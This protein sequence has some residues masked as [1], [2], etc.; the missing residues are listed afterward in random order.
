MKNKNKKNLIIISLAILLCAVVASVLYTQR[1]PSTN[2]SAFTQ[3]AD[4]V[5]ESI[6]TK[7]N[8]A[9][10]EPTQPKQV[11]E[12]PIVTPDTQAIVTDSPPILPDNTTPVP[13]E[14]QISDSVDNQKVAISTPSVSLPITPIVETPAPI[15]YTSNECDSDFEATMLSLIN[16]H[17]KENGVGRLFLALELRQ[18]ACAHSEWMISNGLSHTGVNKSTPFERCERAKTACWAENIAMNSNP[19][20]QIL[21]DQFKNSAGHNANMLNKNYTVIGIGYTGG[22]V[23]QLFR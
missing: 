9:I 8:P 21:F 13:D 7:T 12:T 5:S 4:V 17:R 6:A 18:V 22:F 16:A 15:L 19:S 3:R 1:I 2:S 23:T 20:P 14:S 11:V 10:I